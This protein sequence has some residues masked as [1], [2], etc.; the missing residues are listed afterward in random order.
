M[1]AAST[2]CGIWTVACGS[3]AVTSGGFDARALPPCPGG[4]MVILSFRLRAVRADGVTP[5]RRSRG[6]R[7]SVSGSPCVGLEKQALLRGR[8]RSRPFEVFRDQLRE[9]RG[10]RPVEAVAADRREVPGALT[11]VAAGAVDQQTLPLAG[12]RDFRQLRRE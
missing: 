7:W 9:H 6:P 11:R 8:R 2:H 5:S 4:V 10:A 1:A 12:C 3:G